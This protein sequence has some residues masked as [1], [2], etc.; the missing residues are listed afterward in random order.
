[1]DQELLKQE[2]LELEKQLEEA[3]ASK[4]AHDSTGSHVMRLLEIEDKLGEKRRLLR[5]SRAGD[6]A[7]SK[8]DRI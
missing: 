4:P 8:V 7:D 1:V 6:G 5:R 3:K 2:I